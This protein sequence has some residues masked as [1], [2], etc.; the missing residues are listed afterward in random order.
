M[1]SFHYIPD[2]EN[3]ELE[4][5]VEVDDVLFVLYPH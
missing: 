4:K 5:I 2:Q 3:F 1:E